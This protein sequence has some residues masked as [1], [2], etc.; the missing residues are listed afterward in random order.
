[1]AEVD[2]NLTE[3]SICYIE[4]SNKTICKHDVCKSC[5][6]KISRCPVCRTIFKED[7]ENGITLSELVE[8]EQERRQWTHNTIRVICIFLML[9]VPM[10][11]CVLKF[12]G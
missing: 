2:P 12:Y 4:T 5:L 9:A 3:C 1:M 10:L 8:L 7:I 6:V 11:I